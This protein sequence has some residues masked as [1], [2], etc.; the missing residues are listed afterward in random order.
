MDGYGGHGSDVKAIC[1]M[2]DQS[3]NVYDYTISW[4]D[5]Q[6]FLTVLKSTFPYAD[7]GAN[8]L[9]A[10][11]DWTTL[12]STTQTYFNKLSARRIQMG[13]AGLSFRYD[14]RTLL[15]VVRTFLPKRED[16]V[17][18]TWDGMVRYSFGNVVGTDPGYAFDQ[19]QVPFASFESE[20]GNRTA[21][22]AGP[23]P[24]PVTTT[25]TSATVVTTTAVSTSMSAGSTVV[26]T[27]TMTTTSSTTVATT[28]MTPTPTPS[29]SPIVSTCSCDA[30]EGYKSTQA[31]GY[32][33]KRCDRGFGVVLR[34][35]SVMA[36][37]S[38]SWGVERKY[39]IGGGA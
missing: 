21:L 15:A 39:C 30:A 22:V 20:A 28:I 34:A 10:P 19:S 17:G 11:I 35:C 33:I 24:P 7:G 1:Q 9:Y 4:S 38:C 36:N 26:T 12:M 32:A 5:V 31:P 14:W 25:V 23:P 6:K 8:G 18:P 16:M 37:G 3:Q 2:M 27:Q 13:G 29:P